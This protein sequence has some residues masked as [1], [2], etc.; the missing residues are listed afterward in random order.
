M[1]ARMAVPAPVR[2]GRLSALVRLRA[3]VATV[4][5]ALLAGAAF[6]LHLSIGTTVIPPSELIATLLGNPPDDATA[7][8][9]HGFRLPR[10]T[11]ALTA[12]LALGMSGALTQTIAR[13]PLASPD[14]LGVTSA[15]ALGAVAVL[16]LAGGASAGASGIAASVLMPAA[17]LG[18][19]ILAGVATAVL[20]W[21]GG[22]DLH[23]TVL[24]GIGVS[25]L[26]TSLTTWLL[27]LGDVTNAA[28]AVT[29]MSGSL[30]GRE[31]SAIAPS[32]AAIAVLLV[33][34][35]A[36]AH[37]LAL[38]AF[39][40]QTAAGIGVRLGP[41]RLAV[42][43]TAVL[44]ASFAA[45]VAGPISFVALAAPQIA[46]L[47]THTPTPPL[48][49][50]ALVGAVLLLAADVVTAHLF[51]IPLPAGVGTALV[52]VPYLLWLIVLNRRRIA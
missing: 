27:T 19:G 14:I 46:R 33:I 43:A 2:I 23:R 1:S 35:S 47:A 15:A 26:A 30:N 22:I 42:L 49:A 12:G 9:V 31:W 48:W 7:L 3:V 34:G 25:W 16:V 37:Q 28:I 5:L 40:D 10:A 11:A 51:P 18:G 4:A 24:A 52:G 8:V 29:W 21:R 45:L 44:L 32:V 17:A 50:S 20:G 38:T 6:A 41:V 36:L 13:N 39:D